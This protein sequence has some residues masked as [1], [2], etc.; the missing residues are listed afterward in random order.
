MGNVDDDYRAAEQAA[1]EEK[2]AA[3][4]G[5]LKRSGTR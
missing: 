1:I 2:F 4:A 5:S 3:L